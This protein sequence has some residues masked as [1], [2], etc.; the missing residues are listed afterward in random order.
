M[1]ALNPI[2]ESPT[3]K[4][5]DLMLKMIEHSAKIFEERYDGKFYCLLWK[6]VYEEREGLYEKLLKGLT[7]KGIEVIEIENI[8]PEYAH[9]PFKYMIENDGHPNGLANKMIAEY[10]FG[11]LENQD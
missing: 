10:L 11:V 4:K 5:I 9:N 6:A 8:I 1:V 2:F 7:D 3:Q